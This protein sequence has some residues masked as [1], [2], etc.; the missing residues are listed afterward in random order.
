MALWIL[1]IF[2]EHITHCINARTGLIEF[3]MIFFRALSLLLL[4]FVRI[5]T[6]YNGPNECVF[7]FEIALRALFS[8]VSFF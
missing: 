5:A 4:L 1:Y 8:L 2:V 7:G 3:G 6:A